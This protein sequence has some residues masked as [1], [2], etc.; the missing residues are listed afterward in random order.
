MSA[1]VWP[2]IVSY[3]FSCV[4]L[5][6]YIFW[7]D[8]ITCCLLFA[9]SDSSLL[10][11]ASLSRSSSPWF[12][13]WRDGSIATVLPICWFSCI[14]PGFPDLASF[15]YLL[16]RSFPILDSQW[17][18]HGFSFGV[19]SHLLGFEK[20]SD[21]YRLW[22][23]GSLFYWSSRKRNQFGIQVIQIVVEGCNS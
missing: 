7:I 2:R 9:E 20:W 16:T 11:W 21:S 3:G 1:L 14:T 19:R 10:I 22:M 5:T 23:T 4:W 6:P 17:F 12:L 13:N 18:D 15:N 8:S